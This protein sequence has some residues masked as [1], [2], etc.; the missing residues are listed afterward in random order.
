MTF[1]T[2]LFDLFDTLVR[3][4]R[5]RLPEVRINGASVRSTAGHLFPIL[6]PHAPGVDLARFFEA[7]IWSWQEAERLRA[8]DYREVGAPERFGLLFARL[9]L[10]PA[11]IPTEAVEA[12]LAAHKRYL[13]QA[14][15]LPPDH[16]ALV[17]GR[18]RRYR[19]GIVSNFDYAP[20][21][22]W[23]LE[24]EEVSDLFE[25]VVVSAEVG[26]R[27]PKPVI[28]EAAFRR[29]GIGPRDALFVGDRADIDVVGAK[30]VGMAVAWLNP[31]G[32]PPTPGIPAPEY[33]IKALADLGQILASGEPARCNLPKRPRI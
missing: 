14:A 32:E 7:L 29:L 6:A 12:L 15:L 30:A 25:A 24:R 2:I 1:S 22:H 23:I 3:F 33:E 19:L 27:K 16:R 13:A 21:A 4:D 5:N 26:W 18:A 9:G 28:F 11:R 10:D 17:T 8:A 20:T 31:T